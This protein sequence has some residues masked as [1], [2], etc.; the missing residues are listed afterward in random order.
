[1]SHK[2][3]PIYPILIF[4]LALMSACEES[5]H[6][7]SERIVFNVSADKSQAGFSTTPAGNIYLIA[8]SGNSFFKLKSTSAVQDSLFNP[9][10]LEITITLFGDLIP[11]LTDNPN[12]YRV[13]TQFQFQ[14]GIIQVSHT[15]K[16]SPITNPEGDT[17]YAIRG[18]GMVSSGGETFKNISGLFYEESTY[19][20]SPDTS[21]QSSVQRL[22]TKIDCRYE[23]IIDF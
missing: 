10:R 11:S 5:D 21:E 15:N 20:I 18:E 6:H 16:A 13:N 2:S 14:G 3:L 4:L 12:G 7:S 19:K 8:T 9:E 23:L 17:L 22:I 1:M